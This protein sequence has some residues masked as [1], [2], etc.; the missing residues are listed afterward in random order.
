MRVAI[1]GL[2]GSFHDEAAQKL[3]SGQNF[4]LVECMSFPEVFD[5]VYQG[6]ANYG[7]VAT[8]NNVYGP[9]DGVQALFDK[10]RPHIL[11]GVTLH[12]DQY[13]IGHKPYNIDS[14]DTSSARILSQPPALSQAKTWLD[15]HL[16]EAQRI[17]TEDTAASVKKVVQD[18]VDRQLAVAGKHA[19]ELYKGVI[20]AGPLN[21]Q[22]NDTSFVLFQK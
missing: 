9:I 8:I 15:A 2:R 22:V 20:L 14:L 10:F 7:V 17:E 18:Q 13:L 1:Q 6:R 21:T 11:D 4:E 19:A 16:P 3:M 5:M 12:I